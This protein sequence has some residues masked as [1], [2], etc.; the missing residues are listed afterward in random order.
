VASSGNERFDTR[1]NEP[2]HTDDMSAQTLNDGLETETEIRRAIVNLLRDIF[3]NPFRAVSVDAG[4]LTANVVSVA[5]KLYESRDFAAMP[6][7]ADALQVA[8]C[9]NAHVL[10][11]CRSDSPHCRGCWV[12]N[13]VLGKS[14]LPSADGSGGC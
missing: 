1:N 13:A 14:A 12:I 8:G 4:W 9:K 11:H 6:I 10:N 7:L 5:R 3:G 2:K